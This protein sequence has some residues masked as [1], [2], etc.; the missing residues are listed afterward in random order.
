MGRLWAFDVFIS[1]SDRYL[2]APNMGNIMISNEG[3]IYG[4]DQAMG[5]STTD[6]G[7]SIGELKAARQLEDIMDGGA[8]L[9]FCKTIYSDVNSDIE[10]YD[11]ND[12]VA[13]CIYFEKGILDALP[14]ISS[15]SMEQVLAARGQLPGEVQSVAEHIGLGGMSGI[16]KAFGSTILGVRSR[17][18]PI[19]GAI[20]RERRNHERL[21][22]IDPVEQSNT[23]GKQIRSNYY[24]KLG[25]APKKEEEQTQFDMEL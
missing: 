17:P 1:N 10:D 5:M 24:S 19:P 6:E 13:F 11:L 15:I 7:G 21:E 25:L 9:A 8:R 16:I 18:V 23:K 4:I 14:G 22:E 3:I 20:P 2:T 12:E